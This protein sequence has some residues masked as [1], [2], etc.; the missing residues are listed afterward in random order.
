MPLTSEQEFALVQNAMSMRYQLLKAQQLDNVNRDFNKECGYPNEVTAQLCKQLYKREGVAKRVVHILP[1]ESWK[2]DPAVYEDEDEEVETAFEKAWIAVVKKHNLYHKLKRA[3]RMCGIGTFGV[4]MLGLDDGKTPEN[5]VEGMTF[6]NT[7]QLTGYAKTKLLY[8]R[9]FDETQ[10]QI[11]EYDSDPKSWRFGSPKFYNINF[12]QVDTQTQSPQPPVNQTKVHWHRIIHLADGCEA[13]EVFGTMR[14]EPVFDRLMDIRKVLGSSAEMFWKGGFPGISFETDPSVAATADFDK[15]SMREEMENYQNG[16]QRYIA[17]VGVSAKSLAP[18]VAEPG[19]HFETY[20]KAI[21]VSLAIP[22]RIFVGSE[23]AQL[24]S[25]QDK[26]AW[27][28]R[29]KDRQEKHITPVILQPVAMRFIGLG[30]CPPLAD[31]EAQVHVKWMDLHTP[32]AK[33]KADVAKILTEAM[34]TYV[35]SGGDALMQ[36]KDFLMRIMGFNEE[37]AEAIMDATEEFME[38]QN[39]DAEENLDDDGNPID[40]PNAP[41]GTGAG[42]VGSRFKP[43]AK[44]GKKEDPAPVKVKEGEKLVDPKTVVGKKPKKKAVAKK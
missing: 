6:D 37:E 17:M 43:H 40:D 2:M 32:T 20:I 14:M 28:E 41:A 9:T 39:L 36:P 10:V 19:S 3:D 27:N 35:Q 18:Q 42:A 44:Q 22:Y 15:K 30:I 33:D 25:E 5:E 4:I 26:T 38:E 29:L 8:L 31:K 16:L 13:S 1:D 34:T 11:A 21:C 7:G 12:A 23:A 24:A